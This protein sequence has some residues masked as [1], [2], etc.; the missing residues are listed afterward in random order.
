MSEE[1]DVRQ[2]KRRGDH[3]I[4]VSR[5]QKI[6][7]LYTSVPKT[8]AKREPSERSARDHQPTLTRYI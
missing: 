1:G 8:K 3:N 6:K 5:Q 7:Y 4:V 2:E